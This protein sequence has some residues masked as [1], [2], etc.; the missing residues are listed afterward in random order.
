MT[1]DEA[2]KMAIEALETADAIVWQ[3]SGVHYEKL[4]S[5]LQVCK[6]ALEQPALTKDEALKMAIEALETADA[7][8]WQYSGVHYE[9]L[10]SALNA[11]KEALEQLAQ[12]PVADDELHLAKHAKEYHGLTLNQFKLMCNEADKRYEGQF[13]S[14]VDKNLAVESFYEGFKVAIKKA[15]EQ[16]TQESMDWISVDKKL[17]ELN[18]EVMTWGSGTANN[19]FGYMQAWYSKDGWQELDSCGD[20][21]NDIPPTHW[22]PL[23]IYT[24]PHQWQGLTDNEVDNIYSCAEGVH[25]FRDIVRAIE[26]ALKEKNT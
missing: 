7:I 26:Q 3:Y 18:T 14:S 15:K 13:A 16:S 17:P 1:K 2:L 6:E 19:S 9:K 23:S 20:F 25:D 11:C 12:E 22:I 8:V 10:Q 24:H 5:A 4:Q 21:F